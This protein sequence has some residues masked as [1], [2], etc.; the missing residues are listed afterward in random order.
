MMEPLPTDIT[1]LQALVRQLQA[2]NAALKAEIAALNARL[3]SDSHNS[4][5]PP[6]TDGL[7]KRP[8][9]PKPSGR[10][11]GGQPGHQGKTLAM[12]TSP[13]A[14]IPC[15][16]ARCACGASLQDVPG[17]VVER[18]QV[19]DLPTPTLVITE[20]HRLQCQCP[21]CGA[22]QAG[23]F[24]AHVTAPTQY[25]PNVL[26][27]ATLLNTG[28][29]VPFK[30]V[31]QIFTDLFGSA[32]NEQTLVRANTRCYDALAASEAA[33]RTQLLAAPV[34]H[35]DETGIRV[36]GH[37]AWQHV[38]SNA[39]ATYLF[40]HAKRGTA[41]LDSAD[42][43]LPTYQ[44]WAIHDCWAS[45]F[46]Y[47]ACQHGLCGA[48]LLRE[49]TALAE[50][51]CAW[52]HQMH[53]LLLTLYRQ[54]Q[55]G[56]GTVRH[57]ERWSQLYD[58]VCRRAQ[59]EE[60]PPTRTHRKGKARRTKGRNLVERLIRYKSAVLAFAWHQ[61][62]PF[63]NNQ[64]E[65]DVRPSKVKQKIAGSFRTLKGAHHYARIQSFIATAR[66]QQRSL[67]KELCAIFQGSSFLLNPG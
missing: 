25:G 10:K 40:V 16:P 31:R 20:Y 37:L 41:A 9:L 43:L 19:F 42:S 15:P 24:P 2:A 50:Q 12:V 18:R 48:H 39:A 32:V 4:H 30:N 6:A 54:S 45:Y 35:F 17:T 47:H 62:V 49:L 36:A 27:L 11:R 66:K 53:T 55:R 1:T 26:A 57:S 33:I 60:P 63:T 3:H 28:Y 14:T 61:E 21:A 51:G 34:C 8:A 59:R 13:D 52:A 29:R 65:R 67:F 22:T 58:A 38:V 64:A 5:Q 44:G 23:V 46:G 7:R 56:T